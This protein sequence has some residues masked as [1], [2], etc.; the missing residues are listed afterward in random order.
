MLKYLNYSELSNHYLKEYI[1]YIN[2]L[3]VN[4]S[5]KEVLADTGLI[6]GNPL[7]YLYYPCLFSTCFAVSQSQLDKL[8]I[9]GYLYYQSVI[10]L[11]E[12]IDDNKKDNIALVLICQEESIKI[13]TSIFGL[14]SNY[15]KLWNNR[16]SEY[17]KAI[18]I[19]KKLFNNPNTTFHEYV[20]LADYKAAFGKAAVDSVFILFGEKQGEIYERLL[21]SHEYFSVAFQLNDDIQ[22]FKKDIKNNQF[23]WAVYSM[24]SDLVNNHSSN[25]LN[26]LFYIKGHA[27][28]ILNIALQYMDKASNI[29]IND[30]VP[31]WKAVLETTK[32]QLLN[33]I[34]EI[35]TY[36]E[37]LSSE[38]SLSTTIIEKNTSNSSIERAVKFIQFKQDKNGSW[39][40]YV[41]QG[42]ISNIWTTAYVLAKISFGPLKSLFQSEI[43]K[44]LSFLNEN[45]SNNLWSYNTT[46]IEDAD[47][48][49]FALLA[50]Y[51]NDIPINDQTIYNWYQYQKDNGAFSTYKNAQNL[52]ENLSDKRID[53]VD[54]WVS[55]HQCVSSVA[56]YFLAK[57]GI[58]SEVFDKLEKYFDEKTGS[59]ITA[60]WWTSSIY[61]L[62]Y[63]CQAYYTLRKFDRV[64]ILLTNLKKFQ[65][66]DGSFSDG[67]G[68]NFFY[69]GLA[70]DSYVLEYR[71]YKNEVENLVSHILR[72][73]YSDG[74]W[75][76]SHSLQIPNAGG[77][78]PEKIEFTISTRGTNVRAKEFNR[79]F[80]TSTILRALAN[81]E[82]AKTNPKI[83]R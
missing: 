68:T 6:H 49:N 22:D 65:N 70:L 15:W 18:Q 23:N 57:S 42:G 61:T 4:D 20:K 66:P 60:Y 1:H 19:E 56:F 2:S 38:I 74:S 53:S 3:H 17:F 41:N 82:Q 69:S 67:Y 75:E 5:F 9:A 78:I 44:G 28:K 16:R 62:S 48:T 35:E 34:I 72:N 40:D 37:L 25:E 30:D 10:F 73:Q 83:G 54:G 36:L 7:Y 47:S 21:K 32:R 45:K 58:R 64:N 27:K 29:I 26:K 43:Q 51:N 33:S 13:L 12:V 14:E 55:E 59:G 79:L 76:N 11:D 50:L 77:L 71:K 8:C 31:I 24:P 63:L 80:T 46:W 39:K 52:M 81:Y